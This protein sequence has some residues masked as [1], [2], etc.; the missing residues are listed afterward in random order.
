MPLDLLRAAPGPLVLAYHAGPTLLPA[1]PPSWA[2]VADLDGRYAGAAS[3][4]EVDAARR[5]S[6]ARGPLVLVG[7]S[8]GCQRVREL[9]RAG[10]HPVAV[11]ALDGIS[12]DVPPTAAQMAPWREVCAGARLGELLAILT[13]TEQVYTSVDL[14]PGQRFA[15]TLDTCSA[16]WLERSP[17]A[18]TRLSPERSPYIDGALRV[19]VHASARYDAAAHVREVEE[20]GPR[21]LREVVV[22]WVAARFVEI[23]TDDRGSGAL[24]TSPGHEQAGRAEGAGGG[25]VGRGGAGVLG[26]DLP[27]RGIRRGDRG[28]DVRHLQQ[29]LLAAGYSPGP[30]DGVWGPRTEAALV[31]FQGERGLTEEGAGPETMAALEVGP[32]SS[33]D[34]PAGGAPVN[35]SPLAAALLAEALLDLEAG[36]AEDP[37]GSNDGPAL[38]RLYFTPAGVAPGVSWCSLALRAWYVRACRRLGVP[39]TLLPLVTPVA[40]SW[41]RALGPAFRPRARL[42]E[43]LERGEVGPGAVVTFDRGTAAWQG[44]VGVVVEAY[45]KRDVWTLRVVSGNDGDRVRVTEHSVDE[46][47]LR[48]AG[49]IG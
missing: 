2:V 30:L 13:C 19:E 29:L 34:G 32:N 17:V 33:T 41:E 21:L 48:G 22:P 5:L 35:Q 25:D 40:K 38:R 26:A 10:A 47:L 20:H 9:W 37:P 11:V 1:L 45:R 23:D 7:F 46:V 24:A 31:A 3:A 4:A 36:V 44:H 27:L 28:P 18:V 42:A 39:A 14:P 8:A 16:L 49:M 6:G 15:A 43:A 12:G